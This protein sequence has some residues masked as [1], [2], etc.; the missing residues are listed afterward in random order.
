[1]GNLEYKIVENFLADIKKE[2]G[3]EDDKTIKVAELKKIEQE[4]KTIEKFVQEFRK[5]TRESSYERQLLI[6][7]FK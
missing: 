7:K 2:F 4:N 6:E 1:L 3:R 5:I